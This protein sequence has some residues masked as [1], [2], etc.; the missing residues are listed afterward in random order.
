MGE[1]VQH[2][3]EDVELHELKQVHQPSVLL[4]RLHAQGLPLY[5]LSNMP[6]PYAQHLERAH[7][8]VGWF[9]DGVFSA[10]VHLNKPEPAI[11]ELAAA[12]FGTA[13]PGGVPAGGPAVPPPCRAAASMTPPPALGHQGTLPPSPPVPPRGPAPVPLPPAPPPH[14]PNTRP[15]LPTFFFLKSPHHPK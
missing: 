15:H 5:F 6:E 2:L 9:R 8:F 12:R 4:Q 7:D 11:F 13:R 14:T 10:R 3:N 1:S